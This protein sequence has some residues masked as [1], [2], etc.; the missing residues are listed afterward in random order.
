MNFVIVFIG[1]GFGG[2]LRHL[3]N[4]A[5]PRLLGSSFPFATL[6][7]NI[8]GCLLMGL[9]V[10]YLTFR[11][12]EAVNP[13]YRLFLATGILGGYTTFSAFSLDTLLL[14][15]RGEPGAALLYV[16]G[17]VGISMLAVCAGFY[18]VRALS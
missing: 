10:G 4:V 15:E 13:M 14:M 12:G 9:V 11:G 18:L 7:V 3:M 1:A 2:V 6:L 5:V 16:A 17:S 8:S